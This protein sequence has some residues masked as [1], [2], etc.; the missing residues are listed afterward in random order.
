MFTQSGST[1]VL[2]KLHSIL[3]QNAS[4]FAAKRISFCGKM[5]IKV[6]KAK[7]FFHTVLFGYISKMT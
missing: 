7:R 6:Y 1:A 2:G 3:R 5:E 4:H